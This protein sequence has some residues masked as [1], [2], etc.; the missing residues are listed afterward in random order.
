MGRVRSQ[1]P[2]FNGAIQTGTGKGVC[3]FG[4]EFDLHDVVGVPLEHLGAI[5]ATIPIPE[6]DG[7][8]VTAGQD[9]RQGRMDLETTNVVGMSFKFLDFFHGIVVEHA[10]SHIIGRCQ[11]PLLACDKLGASHGQF[12]DLKGLDTAA[13]FVV[14]DHHIATVQ[15][16]KDPRIVGVEV[17]ALHALGRGGQFLFDIQSERLQLC[18]SEYISINCMVP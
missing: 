7:H 11:K 5:K 15:G 2:Y 16:S 18:R 17:H 12:A 8:V 14:P 6:L 1:S 9:I 3:I 13:A 10:E 4:V